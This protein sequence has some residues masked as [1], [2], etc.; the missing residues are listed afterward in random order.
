VDLVARTSTVG[1]RTVVSVSGEID[2]A[3]IPKLHDALTRAVA[4]APPSSTVFV[5]LD[6][7]Y[8]CDD[9]GLGVL[10]G[11]AG[12][13][14]QAGGEMIVVCSPG[15]LRERLAQTGFDRA[16]TVVASFARADAAPPEPAH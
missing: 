13:A 9:S 6:G 2:L 1:G 11:A 3:T 16:V 15:P 10:M 4:S 7:V 8:V 5:D 14:R 12:R